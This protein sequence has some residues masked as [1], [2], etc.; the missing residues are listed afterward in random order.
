MSFSYEVKEELSGHQ[1]NARHC[2]IAEL[3]VLLMH[4]GQIQENGSLQIAI[5]NE[6]VYKKTTS[7]LRKMYNL[8]FSHFDED[9]EVYKETKY[10]ESKYKEAQNDNFEDE[11]NRKL[12]VENKTADNKIVD[13]KNIEIRDIE[14]VSRICKVTKFDEIKDGRISELLLK[15]GCCRRAFLEATFLCIGSMSDPEKSYHLEFVCSS[16]SQAEQVKQ[17]LADFDIEA[18][19]TKRKKY[20]V[21]YLKEGAAIVELLNIIVAHKALMELE[22]LRILKEVRNDVNRRCNCDAANINKALQAAEKQIADIEYL[23]DNYGFA[24]LSDSLK[25]IAVVRLEHPDASLKDLGEFLDPP[26][27]KSGVNHRLRKLS[28]LAEQCRESQ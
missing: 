23:R 7:L 28:E 14:V 3:A 22:N 21:V 9:E 16:E 20:F 19:I 10:K 4:M 2:Q 13:N 17:I 24:K 6:A 27:G 1:Q 11:V 25:E 8:K 18:K 12:N 15:S 26:V 5:E